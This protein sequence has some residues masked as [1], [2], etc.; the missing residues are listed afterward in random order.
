VSTSK[1]EKPVEDDRNAAFTEDN[2]IAA[3]FVKSL[4]PTLY[5]VYNSSAGPGIRHKCVAG[6]LRMLYF[7]SPEVLNDVLEVY[8]VSSQIAALLGSRD[9]KV[10]VSALQMAH[11]LMDKLPE[12]FR[13][14]FRKEGV[15]HEIEKL[16]AVT[17]GPSGVASSTSSATASASTAINDERESGG[18]KDEE[19]RKQ[20]LLSSATYSP[21]MTRRRLSDI[22]RRRHARQ[23]SKDEPSP[24]PPRASSVE[25]PSKGSSVVRAFRFGKK[26]KESGASKTKSSGSGSGSDSLNMSTMSSMITSETTLSSYLLSTPPGVVTSEQTPTP[27]PPAIILPTVRPHSIAQFSSIVPPKP[28]MP[29]STVV[30]EFTPLVSASTISVTPTPSLLTPSTVPTTDPARTAPATEHKNNQAQVKVEDLSM[31]EWEDFERKFKENIAKA[32]TQSCRKEPRS[33]GLKSLQHDFK[34]ENV[35]LEVEEQGTALV[36][37]LALQIPESTP[38]QTVS[39]IMGRDLVGLLKKAESK[40][41]LTEVFGSKEYVVSEPSRSPTHTPTEMVKEDSGGS[42]PLGAIAGGAGGAV[43]ILILIILGVYT[44]KKNQRGSFSPNTRVAPQPEHGEPVPTK[45]LSA[46]LIVQ[47]AESQ[48]WAK[49][50]KLEEPP[51]LISDNKM[52]AAPLTN[53]WVEVTEIE[54]M[55]ELENI[56]MQDLAQ[57]METPGTLP[58]RHRGQIGN[59]SSWPE[60]DHRTSAGRLTSKS[61]LPPIGTKLN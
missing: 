43:L 20:E 44:C 1:A 7:S 2:E 26:L 14:Y 50:K 54:S 16:A 58:Q 25:L 38:D 8:P 22:L 60:A 28:D 51:S 37:K 59:P 27:S 3:T 57:P 5:C 36:I 11:I 12:V 42:L 32:A 15:V 10:V 45:K 21:P 24:P 19:A 39:V 29:S 31:K 4:F 13:I 17:G 9:Q 34:P 56:P 47:E 49:P 18:A 48:A 23:S 35:L 40:S 41:L 30:G 53:N 46:P 33:C 61:S 55:R 52:V 6:L